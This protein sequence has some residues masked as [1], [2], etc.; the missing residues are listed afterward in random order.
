[1]LKYLKQYRRKGVLKFT[2]GGWI[3]GKLRVLN[4]GNKEEVH[5]LTVD[6]NSKLVIT[7]YTAVARFKGVF[8]SILKKKK[9]VTI[10]VISKVVNDE[11]VHEPIVLEGGVYKL[12]EVL[13]LI[14]NTTKEQYKLNGIEINPSLDSILVSSTSLPREELR[15]HVYFSK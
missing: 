1:M 10:A 2:N 13:G 9:L 8:A 6:N 14:T 7:F 11:I 4:V 12:A 3:T 5:L 15:G